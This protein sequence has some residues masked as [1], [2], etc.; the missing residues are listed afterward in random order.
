MAGSLAN[1]ATSISAWNHHRVMSLFSRSHG[2]RGDAVFDAPRRARPQPTDRK[3]TPERPGRHPHG[4]PWGRVETG[5][6]GMSKIERGTP[7]D[8]SLS[9]VD[10]EV[11]L[12]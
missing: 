6:S 10:R 9:R 7:T 1:P 2:P 3:G 12:P 4:G 5:S 11:R 8:H